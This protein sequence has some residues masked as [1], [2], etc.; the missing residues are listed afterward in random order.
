[1]GDVYK[2]QHGVWVWR[3]TGNPVPVLAKFEVG[4]G[5]T[6]PPAPNKSEDAA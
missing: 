4:S 1:V 5:D 6:K 3:D 2:D